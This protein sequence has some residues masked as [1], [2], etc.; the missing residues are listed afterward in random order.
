M[1]KFTDS[2]PSKIIAKS[3][4][5]RPKPSLQEIYD[6]DRIVPPAHMREESRVDMGH[7]DI[8]VERY[9]DKG[10]HDKEVDKIWRKTWQW[11]CRLEDIPNVGDHVVYT[12]VHDSLIV[13]RTGEG[14]DDIHAYVNSCLHRGTMLRKEGGCVKQFRCPFHGFTWNL[15]GTLK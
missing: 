1:A 13:V 11:A 14:Q 3:P 9:F 5:G 2:D 6:T 10:Y 15:D 4:P 12:I 8:S 7:K